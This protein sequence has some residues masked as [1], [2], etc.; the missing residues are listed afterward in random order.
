MFSV[1]FFLTILTALP[2]CADNDKDSNQKDD[3]KSESPANT[4]SDDKSD[5]K[6]MD[7]D[8]REVSD[9]L[10]QSLMER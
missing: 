6:T 5:A 8:Q 2:L 7:R 1:A 9:A 4:S 3:S 10:M